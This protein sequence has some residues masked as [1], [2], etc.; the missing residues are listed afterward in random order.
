MSKPLRF[1]TKV[2]VGFDDDQLL[3]IDAWRRQ[4]DD[5]PNR[6]ESIRRLVERGLTAAKLEEPPSK[7]KRSK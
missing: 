2:L 5:L 4:Q 3:A 6:S 1:P 7:R